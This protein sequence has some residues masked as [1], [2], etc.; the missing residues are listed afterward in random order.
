MKILAGCCPAGRCC[1]RWP[2]RLPARS[3]HRRRC[4]IRASGS[5]R[6]PTARRSST[7]T[8]TCRPISRSSRAPAS[9]PSAATTTAPTAPASAKSCYHHPSKTLTKAELTAIEHAGMSVYVVFQ[10]CGAQCV[11]FDLQNKETAEKGRKDAEGAVAAWRTSSASPPTRRSISPST[12]ILRPA[13]TARCRPRGS[14]RASRPISIRSTRCFAQT[15]WQVGVYGAGITCQRLKASG[16]AKYFWLSTS[17]GH[18][19]HA[20]SSS[21]AGSGI[22]FRTS[23]RSSA[24]T[25]RNTFDTDVDQSGERRISASGR[26][27]GRRRRTIPVAAIDILASRAFVK[28]GCPSSAAP[29]QRQK[30]RAAAKTA[31]VQFDVPHPDVG[32][33]TAISES[34]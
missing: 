22:C 31:R 30:P 29:A 21:T 32:R 9:R 23:P 19:R 27:A 6:R 14:G 18:H 16:K 15:R 3:R 2:R 10:H 33:A 1:N 4:P 34:A 25:R 26:R 5:A 13:A 24:A 28:S 7:A 11:N 12:S 20:A 17:L 8:S